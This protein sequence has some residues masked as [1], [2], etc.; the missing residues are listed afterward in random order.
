MANIIVNWV[1]ANVLNVVAFI[2]HTMGIYAIIVY[3]KQSNQTLILSNLSIVEITMTICE[4]V[5]DIVRLVRY[6]ED[7]FNSVKG[8][9]DLLLNRLPP[10]YDE[11]NAFFYITVGIKI[12]LIMTLLTIDRLICAIDPLKYKVYLTTSRMKKI[13]IAS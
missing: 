10:V 6:R 1:L 5:N 7:V 11:I 3:K 12:V 13:L 2:F 9:H 8:M 4:I